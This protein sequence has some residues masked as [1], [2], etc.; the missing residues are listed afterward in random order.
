MMEGLARSEGSS[1]KSCCSYWHLQ[2]ATANAE[3]ALANK[4][5]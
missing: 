4:I 1:R 2:F 3:D 5:K